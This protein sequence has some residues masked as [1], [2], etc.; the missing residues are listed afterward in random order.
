MND[1]IIER[2]RIRELLEHYCDTI[3]QRDWGNFAKFWT[4]DAIWESLEPLNMRAEGRDQVVKVIREARDRNPF[5]TQIITGFV[6]DDISGAT[7]RAHHTLCVMCKSPAG[8][9]YSTVGLY[10]DELRRSDDGWRFCKRSYRPKWFD[11]EP[12]R[13]DVIESAV[14][15]GSIGAL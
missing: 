11:P 13:G 5:L 15:A 12:P 6:V 2:L 7:A 4:E 14:R 1:D 10:S 3:N 9:G 8:T